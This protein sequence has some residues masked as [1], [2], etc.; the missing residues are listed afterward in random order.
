MIRVTLIFLCDLRLV[1]GWIFDFLAP[2][3]W[4]TIQYLFSQPKHMG[5]VPDLY[6]GTVEAQKVGKPRLPFPI[7]AFLIANSIALEACRVSNA[8][9]IWSPEM[10]HF[11]QQVNWNVIWSI[12]GSSSFFLGRDRENRREMGGGYTLKV[13]T[14]ILFGSPLSSEPRFL[15]FESLKLN[16]EF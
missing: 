9:R 7:C 14:K 10:V 11:F 16:S 6:F 4:T 8:R 3:R 15:E 13:G 5:Q 12:C 1:S 2:G